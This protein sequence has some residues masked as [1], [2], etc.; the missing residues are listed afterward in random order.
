MNGVALEIR[1]SDDHSVI[2]TSEHGARGNAIATLSALGYP[3]DTH[4]IIQI[5]DSGAVFLGLRG[6]DHLY[7]KISSLSRPA[8][9]TFDFVVTVRITG[10]RDGWSRTILDTPKFVLASD[11]GGGCIYTWVTAHSAAM[12]MFRDIARP[13]DSWHITLAPFER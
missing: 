6:H 5:D 8:R 9:Q 10:V 1:L 13:G 4:D 12:D 7:V 2:H 3:L 11:A